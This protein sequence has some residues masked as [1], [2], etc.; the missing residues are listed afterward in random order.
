MKIKASDRKEFLNLAYALVK[1]VVTKN[2]Y[3]DI[4][5]KLKDLCTTNFCMKWLKFWHERCENFVPAYCG[6]FLPS[7]NIAESGQSGMCAQQPHGKM[8]SLVDAT[9]KDISKQMHQDTMFKAAVTNQPVDMGKSLNLLDLQLYARS[10][11]E[12]CAP[13]LAQNLAE[14]N[15]WLEDSAL[16]N[17]TT[18]EYNF[19]HLKI[20][21]TSLLIWRKKRILYQ[22]I[23]LM[24]TIIKG[25]KN[26]V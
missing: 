2:E 22:K 8:L 13:I 18:R 6:F 17:D 26:H 11:Q 14:G 15:Q 21:H 9:Y 20:L 1:D 25:N 4:L 10:E 12:K 5:T 16:E 3:F 7:M 24:N 23:I 19:S